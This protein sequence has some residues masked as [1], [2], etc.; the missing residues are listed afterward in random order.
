M[1]PKPK[2]LE[3]PDTRLTLDLPAV[4]HLVG[5]SDRTVRRM[6]ER[7]EFPRPFH[8]KRSLRWLRAE[9]EAWVRERSLRAQMTK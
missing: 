7:D 8:V 1:D 4:T 5:V 9:V 2:S 6:W 3:P